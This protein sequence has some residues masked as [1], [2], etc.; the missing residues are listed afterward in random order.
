ML[1]KGV[2]Q[3]ADGIIQGSEELA[4]NIRLAIEE[5]KKPFIE[6]PKENYLPNYIDFYKTFLS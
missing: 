3:F 2:I 4:E 6:T 1:E 5:S